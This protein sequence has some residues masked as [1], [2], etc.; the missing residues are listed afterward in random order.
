[1]NLFFF[2]ARGG[3]AKVQVELEVEGAQRQQKRRLLP[4]RLREGGQMH[5]DQPDW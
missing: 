4:A 5:V 1:M 3:L 2:Q